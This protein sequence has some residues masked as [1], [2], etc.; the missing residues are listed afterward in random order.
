MIRLHGRARF[1]LAL[2]AASLC[3]GCFGCGPSFDFGLVQG[4]VTL[5]KKP[6]EGATVQFYPIIKDGQPVPPTSSATTDASGHYELVARNDQ[7]GAVIGPHKVI[8]LYPA[9]G[10]G[11]PANRTPIPQK[12]T[13]AAKTPLLVDVKPGPGEYPLELK[14]K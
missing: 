10:G 5:D 2:L 6:V 7:K 8:V 3:F 12:Y 13:I 11:E 4:T 14:S 1:G 9:L